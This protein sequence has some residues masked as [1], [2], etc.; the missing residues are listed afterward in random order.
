M[1]VSDDD[2][3]SC[4]SRF[5]VEHVDVVDNGIDRA[6]FERGRPTRPGSHPVPR[7]LDW[8]P[9]LDALRLLLDA[10]SRPC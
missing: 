4:A 5:G 2:A 9:N 8:R 10:F 1:A 3:R 6:Y 7:R